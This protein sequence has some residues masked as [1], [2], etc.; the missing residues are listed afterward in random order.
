MSGWGDII[1]GLIPLAQ[2]EVT[3]EEQIQKK[4]KKANEDFERSGFKFPSNSTIE[5]IGKESI[6]PIGNSTVEISN[7]SATHPQSTSAELADMQ[8][9]IERLK[10]E[11][12]LSKTVN[13]SLL[14]R[15]SVQQQP[16][17]VEECIYDLCVGRKER[18]NGIRQE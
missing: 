7:Q 4:I 18:R 6:Y 3:E 9:E 1:K 16:K 8:K 2:A 10:T 5:S 12:E 17:S 11:L 13:Q 14:T 15:T